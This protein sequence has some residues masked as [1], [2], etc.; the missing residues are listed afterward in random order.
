VVA[1]RVEMG[2]AANIQRIEVSAISLFLTIK[3]SFS[4]K[5]LKGQS[6]GE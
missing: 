2:W 1:T 4:R 6:A 5:D 3:L